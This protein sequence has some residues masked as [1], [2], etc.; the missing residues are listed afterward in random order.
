MI[1]IGRGMAGLVAAF[2]L[3]RQGHEPLVLE[4]QNRVGGR[5][6]TC[7]TSRP[8][9]TPRPARMRIPRVHDLTL[10]YCE[11]FGLSCGRS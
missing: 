7:A 5:V 10:E 11:L 1:V 3:A 4:A 9:C 8:G 6:L 2:E